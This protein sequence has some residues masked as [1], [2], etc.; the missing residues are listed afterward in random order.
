MLCR[1][2]VY[3]AK[4]NNVCNVIRDLWRQSAIANGSVSMDT[5]PSQPENARKQVAGRQTPW[6]RSHYLPQ[7]VFSDLHPCLSHTDNRSLLPSSFFFFFLNTFTFS[8]EAS[9][10]LPPAVCFSSLLCPTSAPCQNEISN[11][12]KL[13]KTTLLSQTNAKR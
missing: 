6:E 7:C 11:S 2:R 4:C 13:L 10:V 5:C 8:D 9:V 1:K 3:E 12:L